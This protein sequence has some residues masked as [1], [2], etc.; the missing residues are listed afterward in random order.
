MPTPTEPPEHPTPP[1]AP[2][3]DRAWSV[4]RFLA[5]GVS[6]VLI[7]FWIWVFTGGPRKHN[8]DYLKDRA[9]VA[10]AS[11]TCTATTAQ[12]A[13]L[14]GAETTPDH[15]ERAKVVERATV[16]LDRMLVQLATR[17][18][19]NATDVRLVDQWLADYRTYAKAR[20]EYAANLARD[21]HARL[22]LPEKF[23]NPIDDVINTFASD[24]NGIPACDVPGD[25]A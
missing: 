25:V 8:P 22:L 1:A 24:A 7:V 6:L 18:P 5:V 20:H 9:W 14:P 23:G 3:D 19:R 11:A 10:R 16:D 21:K 15:T 12:I 2:R 4:G 17:R 13:K